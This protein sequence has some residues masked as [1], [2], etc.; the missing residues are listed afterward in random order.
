[1]ADTS[2]LFVYT[3]LPYL[4]AMYLAAYRRDLGR[5]ARRV[6]DGATKREWWSVCRYLGLIDADIKKPTMRL[7]RSPLL[8]ASF[9]ALSISLLWIVIP[10]HFSWYYLCAMQMVAALPLLLILVR[11]TGPI[12][13]RPYRDVLPFPR[14]GTRTRHLKELK[15]TGASS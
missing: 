15:G 3:P 8:V 1:M 11:I 10:I 14:R 4:A 6:Q 7:W 13:F 5:I 2:W 9:L 12:P